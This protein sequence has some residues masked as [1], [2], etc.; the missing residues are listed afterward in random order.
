MGFQGISESTTHND[1]P[2]VG[3][4]LGIKIEV[5]KL[6]NADELTFVSTKHTVF[7]DF[8]GY[9]PSIVIREYPTS[10]VAGGFK[11][12]SMLDID[13]LAWPDMTTFCKLMKNH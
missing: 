5:N 2:T 6:A 9:Y 7:L 10:S 12:N 8:L 1:I 13:S 11:I 3:L 4:L